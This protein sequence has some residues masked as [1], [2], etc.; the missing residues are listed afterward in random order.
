MGL[1]VA[2]V[3]ATSLTV[4]QADPPVKENR[5]GDQAESKGRRLDKKPPLGDMSDKDKAAMKKALQAVWENPEV[6]QARD[7]VRRATDTLRE[8][9]RKA[10]GKEDP[11]V[12]ALVEKL[13]GGGK[14]RDWGKKRPGPDGRGGHPQMG[15][16]GG[17]SDR[18]PGFGGDGRGIG[19]AGIMAF[20]GEFTKE[21]TKRLEV[22]KRKA[23]ESEAFRKVMESQR[24]LLK[25]GE[26]LRNRRVEMF[27][28]TRQAMTQAMVEA[29]PEVKPLLE[30]MEKRKKDRPDKPNK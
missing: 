18:G 3:V 14:T 11:R 6:M 30:R 22:A 16:P 15:R 25:Q 1:L 9:I 5:Q 26:E 4:V 28:Q 27:H 24:S 10:V 20:H 8:A 2:F 13:H 29:D 7:E 21:E 12:A 23:M 19:P 17:G